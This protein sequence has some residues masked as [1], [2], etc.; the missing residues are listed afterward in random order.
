MKD[1]VCVCVCVRVCACIQ[2][3]PLALCVLIQAYNVM[4]HFGKIFFFM[5]QY[6]IYGKFIN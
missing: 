5:R 6:Y 4:H 1:G 2:A 3:Y